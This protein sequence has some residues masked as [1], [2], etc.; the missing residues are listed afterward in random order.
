MFDNKP[1]TIAAASGLAAVGGIAAMV[2]SFIVFDPAGE[3]MVLKTGTLLLI[4]AMFFG[5]AGGISSRGQ[6]GWKASTFM[7]FLCAA[8][9][10]AACV[11]GAIGLEIGAAMFIIAVIAAAL[12]STKQSQ[13][14]W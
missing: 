10:V 13:S 7:A 1:T 12:T 8:V 2:A 14:W 11:Y 5:I 9:I 3:D 4:S 6:W